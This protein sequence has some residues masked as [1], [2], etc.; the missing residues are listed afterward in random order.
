M[1]HPAVS[2]IYAWRATQGVPVVFGRSDF[3]QLFMAAFLLLLPVQISTAGLG[4]TRVAPSDAFLL[5]YCIA[6]FPDRRM[7]RVGVFSCWHIA[8]LI[9]F[10]L[11]TLISISATGEL[12]RYVLVNKD[13]G[14]L[15]LFT[16]YAAVAAE[17][18]NYDRIRRMARIFVLSVSVT[19]VLAVLSFYG[20]APWLAV[21]VFRVEYTSRLSG[22]LI[23]P[24]AYGG[25]LA[26]ALAIQVSTYFSK[27]P[28]IGGV[29]GLLFIL[30]LVLGV[31]LTYSR[32][33][34]ISSLMIILGL[35]FV[36]RRACVALIVSIAALI[37]VAVLMADEATV[38]S[39]IRMASRP[40][41]VE[42]RLD[43]VGK[44]LPMFADSPIWGI[45]MGRFFDAHRIIIHNT[46]VWFLTEF[47]LIGL[48]VFSG[49]A[50]WI[51]VRGRVAY[52][53]APP[54]Q[55]P[56]LLGLAMAHVSMLGLSVGVEALYQRHWWLAAAMLVAASSSA[57]GERQSSKV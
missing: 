50:M 21:H 38:A 13:A 31:L 11:A 55:R 24:N 20:Y 9:V 40:E 46:L 8:L 22:M 7:L 44:A 54:S 23:D 45:G 34:W 6:A 10:A 15:L 16:V 57:F 26:V 12:N 18:W 17:S 25:L 14:L 43:I 48:F 5:L 4:S 2:A 19:N 28:V 37:S 39:M 47:G 52:V 56:L 30:S 1:S 35:F 3:A 27:K 33:A 49:Y 32:S 42:S 53:M 36:N 29:L 51:C 41:Q